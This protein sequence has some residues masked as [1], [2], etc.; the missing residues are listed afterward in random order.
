MAP[1][2]TVELTS[3][4]Y[5][6]LGMVPW[7]S[8]SSYLPIEPLP[9]MPE[10]SQMQTSRLTLRPLLLSDLDSFVALR[11]KT[12]IQTNSP[13][14]GRP[15]RS[16]EESKQNLERLQEVDHWYFGI[17]LNKT[18][19]LIGEGG[20]PSTDGHPHSG[21]PEFELLIL[22]EHQR[23]GYGTEVFNTIMDSWWR[24][25]REKRRRQLHPFVVPP[26]TEPGDMVTDGVGI[27]WEYSIKP[28]NHF[29][30]KVLNM[31][32]VSHTGT[33]E[34]WDNREGREGD[35]T[36]WAGSLASNPVEVIVD[37]ESEYSGTPEIGS[38]YVGSPE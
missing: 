2:L 10:R 6:E 4:D 11:S 12:D 35:L 38:P 15:D 23:K 5:E 30:A 31:S 9:T 13:M 26:G 22:P 8:Y 21:W 19:E 24:L 7:F 14:R 18:G 33:F 27:A 20:L 16:P 36:R 1:T 29:F 34:D 28:A 37:E 25:P 17:F 32:P 3:K